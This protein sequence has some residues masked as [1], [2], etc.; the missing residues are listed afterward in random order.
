[1][2]GHNMK[3]EQLVETA[4]VEE[5]PVLIYGYTEAQW[6]KLSTTDKTIAMFLWLKSNLHR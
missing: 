2:G 1:M 3:N 5:A 6:S 4:V